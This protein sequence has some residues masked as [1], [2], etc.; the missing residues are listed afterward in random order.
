MYQIGMNIS[1][2]SSATHPKRL[3]Y[4]E[5][6]IL[7][8]YKYLGDEVGLLLRVI[9]LGVVK[10][11]LD[12]V[13][14]IL[15]TSLRTRYKLL[16]SDTLNLSALVPSSQL[17]SSPQKGRNIWPSSSLVFTACRYPEALAEALRRQQEGKDV[18]V[19]KVHATAR[20]SQAVPTCLESGRL[21]QPLPM[22][23]LRLLVVIS[24]PPIDIKF[25]Q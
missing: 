18:D 24:L 20:V 19:S 17:S 5:S 6:V 13:L 12:S 9:T 7:I 21:R 14:R 10:N 2:R 25:R 1:S 11:L 22:E 23:C 3:L 8:R 4:R 15:I 16:V